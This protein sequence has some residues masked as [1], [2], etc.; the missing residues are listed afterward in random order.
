MTYVHLPHL[1]LKKFSKMFTGPDKILA[2][3]L[4]SECPALFLVP[5]PTCGQHSFT[6]E[7]HYALRVHGVMENNEMRK[8]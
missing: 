7:L 2:V 8:W 3:V 6:I 4:V 1:I 5:L